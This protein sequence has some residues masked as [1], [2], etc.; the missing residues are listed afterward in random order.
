MAT[1]NVVVLNQ[2]SAVT[3]SQ[4]QASVI[5]A[6][7]KQ[8]SRDFAPA[9][10]IDAKVSFLGAGKSVP[11]GSYRLFIL[12]KT[13]VAGDSGYHTADGIGPFANVFVLTA[14]HDWTTVASHELLQMLVNPYGNRAAFVPFDDT[15]LTGL[16]QSSL[17][18]GTYYD[19]EICDPVYPDENAYEIDGVAVSDFVLPVW[20][21]PWLVPSDAAALPIQFDHA[22]KLTGPGQLAPGAMVAASYT[23]RYQLNGPQ[24]SRALG[25]EA[26]QRPNGFVMPRIVTTPKKGEGTGK[27]VQEPT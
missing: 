6:L 14:G 3:D 9:W 23:G 25:M 4:L 26:P 7:Q 27:V 15:T 24:P 20:F 13:N 19:L 10:N 21:T 16:A 8:V 5:P 11:A 12:D 2:S 17:L 22:N 1:I 18:T